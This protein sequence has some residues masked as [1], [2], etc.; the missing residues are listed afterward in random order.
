M[1][2][3]KITP[4]NREDMHEVEVT[5]RFLVHDR[6]LPYAN[7]VAAEAVWHLEDVVIDG[8]ENPSKIEDAVKEAIAEYESKQE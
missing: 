4:F 1:N 8:R 5:V 2:E 6:L 7:F 3:I